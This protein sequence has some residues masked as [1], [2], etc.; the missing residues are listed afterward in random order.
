MTL[1]EKQSIFTELVAYL[2]IEAI[3]KGY[4]V[5]LGEVYRSE[6][7]ALRLFKIGKGVKNSLHTKRLAID[8]NLF[9]NGKYLTQSEDYKSLGEWWERQSTNAFKCAWGGRFKRVDGNHFS[10]EHA[11]VK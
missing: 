7:E 2:I 11:G 3:K 8:L 1:R 5:T 10:I 9:R 6:E 4:D